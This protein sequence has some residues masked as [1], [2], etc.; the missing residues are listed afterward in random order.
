MAT[1]GA[2]FD[3][4]AQ[5]AGGFDGR[6]IWK[7]CTVDMA[8]IVQCTKALYETAAKWCS[9]L[10]V[11]QIAVVLLL[12]FK[13]RLVDMSMKEYVHLIWAI[14]G[15]RFLRAHNGTLYLYVDG[16]WRAFS[17]IFP[18]SVITRVRLVLQYAEGFLRLLPANTPR[19]E[20]GLH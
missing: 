20:E 16:A 14:E 17:G 6:A 18:V 7:D 11:Q 12:T 13:L 15:D 3:D 8:D 4:F 5:K 9:D 10:V 2:M 19:T 1:I